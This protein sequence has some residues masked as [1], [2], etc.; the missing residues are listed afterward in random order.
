MKNA[1]AEAYASVSRKINQVPFL[2]ELIVEPIISAET[3][4]MLEHLPQFEAS[5]YE[6]EANLLAVGGVSQVL[7]Q[8]IEQRYCFMGGRLSEWV[9]HLNRLDLPHGVWRWVTRDQVKAGAGVS[10]VPKKD[11]VSQR[12]LI[13][14]C[15]ANYLWSDVRL[16]HDYGLGGGAALHN[17]ATA[18]QEV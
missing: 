8:E 9:K 17:L 12:K 16:R 7:L 1:N 13:M 18:Q 14:A 2:A 6:K 11:G 3:V 5:C 15:P 4:N 10:A